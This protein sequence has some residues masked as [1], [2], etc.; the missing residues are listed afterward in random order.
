MFVTLQI[1]H[2]KLD[3]HQEAHACTCT[4]AKFI[5]N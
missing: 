4:I 2:Y 5:G 1:I 3:G